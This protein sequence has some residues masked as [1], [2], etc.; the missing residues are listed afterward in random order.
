MF[1]CHLSAF[2]SKFFHCWSLHT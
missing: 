2:Q 1:I